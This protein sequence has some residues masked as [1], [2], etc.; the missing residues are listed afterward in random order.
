MQTTSQYTL[1]GY[2]GLALQ[3]QDAILYFSIKIQEYIS[4][5]LYLR[6]CLFY[7]EIHPRLGS[8]QG[9]CILVI[10]AA[11]CPAAFEERNLGDFSKDNMK[12]KKFTF[13][14]GEQQ[15]KE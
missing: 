14:H 3:E 9:L 13:E 2:L 7:N 5:L 8:Q 6:V 1:E 12:Q 10:I 11:I 4:V 15:T